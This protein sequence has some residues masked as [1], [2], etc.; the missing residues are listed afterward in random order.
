[1]ASPGL[2][3]QSQQVIDRLRAFV[4]RSADFRGGR[5]R[6]IEVLEHPVRLVL[7]STKP[8]KDIIADSY[9]HPRGRGRSYL[10]LPVFDDSGR[11]SAELA[12]IRVAQPAESD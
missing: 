10:E 8:G 6:I 11:V 3:Q 2:M 12:E 5:F 1:M 7:Q 9:G 4:G